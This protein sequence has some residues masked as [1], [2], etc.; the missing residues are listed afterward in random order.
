LKRTAVAAI[1]LSLLVVGAPA[2]HADEVQFLADVHSTHVTAAGGD[3]EL[4]SMGQMACTM[5]GK[6]TITNTV[7]STRKVPGFIFQPRR[8]LR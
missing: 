5:L 2:A 8:S 3:D 7:T 1:G 6:A 4:V